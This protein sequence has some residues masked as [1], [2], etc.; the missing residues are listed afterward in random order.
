MDK[1]V[2]KVTGMTCGKCSA[3]I[4]AALEPH[5]DSVEISLKSGQIRLGGG[6]FEDLERLNGLLVDVGDY[7]LYAMND[8]AIPAQ[9][10]G[11]S[12]KI[13]SSGAG[14]S[15]SLKALFAHPIVEKILVYKPLMLIFGLVIGLTW[16]LHIRQPF[17]ATWETA[18]LDFMGLFFVVFS[19]FKLLNLGGFAKA[20]QAY[21]VIAAKFPVWGFIYPF[22][23]LGLGVCYLM[24][25]M[26]LPA[27]IVTIVLM[28][29]GTAGV[30]L[31]LR[32]G[33]VIQCACIGSVFNLPMSVVTVI[34][35]ALMAFMALAMVL[36][37]FL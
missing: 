33:Q 37:D 7:H 5:V 3:K 17:G 31:A 11:K 18:M 34:E 30:V 36:S 16:Y 10:A 14:F 22:V 20:Y 27:N 24:S 29:V 15:A 25:F 19:F 8:P 1:I 2:Y 12:K 35:N 26:L 4:K 9:P 23:E 28:S 6:A 32:K 13:R 21:D